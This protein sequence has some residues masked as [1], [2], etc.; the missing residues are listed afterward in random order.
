M[1]ELD[2]FSPHRL[3]KVSSRQLKICKNLRTNGEEIFHPNG[4]EYLR[5]NSGR[6]NNNSGR[7]KLLTDH[8]NQEPLKEKNVF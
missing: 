8:P 2:H 6:R 5:Q 7:F 3:D 4:Q 1:F